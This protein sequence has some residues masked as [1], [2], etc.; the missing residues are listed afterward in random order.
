[1]PIFKPS[2]QNNSSAEW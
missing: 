1:M 2:H